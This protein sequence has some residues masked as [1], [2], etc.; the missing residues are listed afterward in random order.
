MLTQWYDNGD[1][2]MI[3]STNGL[4]VDDPQAQLVVM[5]L[6]LSESGHYILPVNKENQQM[7]DNDVRR[8]TT[9]WSHNYDQATALEQTDK[10]DMNKTDKNVE[11][12]FQCQTTETDDQEVKDIDTKKEKTSNPQDNY[13]QVAD[14]EEPIQ[15]MMNDNYMQEYVEVEQEYTGDVFPGHG[16]LRYLQKMYKAVPEE[17]YTKTKRQPVTPRN[18]RSW[19]KKRQGSHFHFWEWCSGS[20]RL[21]LLAMMA[22]V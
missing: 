13:K 21:S 17:F 19:W 1:A 14:D 3:C 16:K 6:L 8:I 10:N 4:R 2:V 20:G 12:Q 11:L 5:R 7:S 18:V 22:Y 15:V 9:L